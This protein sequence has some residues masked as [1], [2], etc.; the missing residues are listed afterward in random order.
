MDLKIALFNLHDL[1]NRSSMLESL[2]K[3]CDIIFL[4]EH[5]L[6]PANI[7]ILYINFN[8]KFTGFAVSGI[9]DIDHRFEWW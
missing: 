9:L 4:Q 3:D 5:W 1:N 7:D 6:L 8:D 2:C